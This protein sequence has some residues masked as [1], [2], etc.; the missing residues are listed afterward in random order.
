MRKYFRSAMRAH[1]ALAFLFAFTLQAFAQTN[2]QVQPRITAQVNAGNLVL[3]KGNTHP[4][5]RAKNDKGI[6][7]D[8]LPA[9]RMLLVLQRSPDQEA[10]LR[11]L[12]DNMHSKASANFHQWLT[13]GQFGQQFG[14]ADADIQ[15]V[16]A[17]LESQGFQ[18]NRVAT[19]KMFIEFSGTAGQIRNAFHTEIHKYVVN[20][21]EHWANASD[22]SI[23]AALGSVVAGVNTMNN[24]RKRPAIRKGQVVRAAETTG[25][26]KPQFTVP[27]CINPAFNNPIFNNT[28][29]GLGPADFA[30]IYNIPAGANG[31]GQTIAIIGDSDICT[32]GGSQT[33]LPLGCTQDDIVAFRTLFGLGAN[34]TQVFVDGADPGING[35]ETEAL[36]DT[37]WTGGVAPNAT[38]LFVT[39]GDTEVT[40]GIDLAAMRVVDN[41]LAPVMNESFGACEQNIGNAGNNF[42]FSLWEQAAAQGIT[43]NISSGDNASAGC[44]DENSESEA[45]QG[46]NVNGIASTP[47]DVAVGGTDF[48]YT[49]AG[50]PSTYWN[51]ANNAGTGLSAKSY[52]PET[53]WNNSCGQINSVITGSCANLPANQDYLLNIV[54]GSGGFSGCAF[55]N[56][57][58]C[59]GY[60]TPPW[61]AGLGVPPANAALGGFRYIPDVSLFA[62][63]GE[64]SNSFYVVCQSDAGAT[65][66]GPSIPFLEVGGT[67]ASV[68]VFGGIMALVNQAMV[69][70]GKSA[71]QGNANYMLYAL[72]GLQTAGGLN[73]NSSLFTP[74]TPLSP[75]CSFNDITK[76]TNSVP[77]FS[78]T[79]Y[80]YT[81]TLT[82]T[83][84]NATFTALTSTPAY[85]TTPG[86]DM[87]TGLGSVNV[88]N[89]ITNWVAEAGSFV[90]TSTT[91]CLSQTPNPPTSCSP[92]Q[93]FTFPH[94]TQVF[95]NAAVTPTSGTVNAGDVSLIGNGSFSSFPPNTT[96]TA[97][98]DHF[99]AATGNSDIYNVANGVTP[100]GAFTFEL[101]GGSYS[102][103]AHF[104]GVNGG[105]GQLF[106]VS[107]STPIPVIITPEASTTTLS[108]LE[109]SLAT[110]NT[111]PISSLTSLPYGS[112]LLT[113]RVDVVGTTVHVVPCPTQANPNQTCPFQFET[114]TGLISITDSGAGLAAVPLNSAGYAEFNTPMFNF[115]GNAVV[116]TVPALAPGNHSLSASFP[117]DP[118][119]QASATAVGSPFQ[120]TIT[121]APTYP[122]IP[123]APTTA[124]ANVSFNVTAFVDTTPNLATTSGSVGNAPSG[125]ITFFN[126]TTQIGNPVGVTATKDADG[127]VAAQATSPAISLTATGSI[128]AKYEGDANYM[129]STSPTYTVTVGGAA[130]FSLGN[131]PPSPNPVTISSPG[132]SGSSTITVS[133]LNGFTGT[134]NLSCSVVSPLN[135]SDPPTCAM[136]AP[137]N[138]VLTNATTSGTGSVTMFTTA[139]SSLW[140]KPVGSPRQPFGLLWIGALAMILFAGLLLILFMPSRKRFGF[141]VIA[142]LLLTT[143]IAMVGC[144]GSGGGQVSTGNPGSTPASYI[145]T[146]T[147]TSGASSH[148]VQVTFNLN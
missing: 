28:C 104:P 65:C 94:G 3:L 27:N 133:S 97:G 147:A 128:I 134:V 30:K 66:M 81:P 5:A 135:L 55:F 47:F 90:P 53:P 127:F 52:I 138:V 137:G 89:L 95:V 41:N 39:A 7:P 26:G 82:L 18:V 2:N 136:S 40:A 103:T 64:E 68:Q 74:A 58:E 98:V 42:Y 132:L 38:V 36:L 50:Y 33:V 21:E 110:G 122:T 56:G 69:N 106:G 16:T 22:P 129:P 71:K 43:V 63:D 88:A 119:Y 108:V 11:K 141:A 75:N 124:S 117:G 118:S 99:D 62:S 125:T 4:L 144:G 61:Q 142:I 101:V 145:V 146:V 6:A 120:L 76:G 72:F 19:S 116:T 12:I 35:D 130:D 15:I 49:V 31:N 70:A 143:G 100:A 67:S 96:P 14:V 112:T 113:V 32:V 60:G 91:L 57:A 20:G 45:F 83:Q 17:W 80:C 84:P 131:T 92:A 109:T 23:P 9:E 24:F 85:V 93:P 86:Y 140:I 54:G 102:I 1:L 139:A 148:S 59:F 37:E 44:D 78:G 46:V 51:A 126:G 115:P 105:A 87:A 34:H 10:T 121:Q 111:A 77:C 13:P 48:D 29:F 114:G 107:D 8:S 25:Q 123:N 73:C 79:N